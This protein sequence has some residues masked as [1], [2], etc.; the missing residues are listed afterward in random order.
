MVTAIRRF[1]RQRFTRWLERRLPAAPAV[2][3]SRRSLFIFPTPA[4]FAF[5]LLIILCWL[6]A[7]NY[8]NN[9]VFAVAC[10]L[11]ALFVVAILHCFANLSGMTVSCLK[12][13][14]GFA[15]QSLT[16]ELLLRQSKHRHREAVLCSFAGGEAVLVTLPGA[17]EQRLKLTVPAERRGLYH[18]GRLRIESIYPL[19]LLRA[20][21]YV[22]LGARGL[23]YPQPVFTERQPSGGRT[24]GDGVVPVGEGGDDFIGLN[25]FRAGDSLKHVA[26]KHYARE[27]GLHTKHYGDVLDRQWWLDW[28]QF[29]G[30]DRE[31]RL[32]R[33]CG[34]LL[35]VDPTGLPYGL[36]LPGVV[37]EPA[38][39]DAHR[40]QLLRELALFDQPQREKRP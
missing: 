7:T 29:P 18:L 8:E 16:V 2:T 14:P 39:G 13:S 15:G 20:W 9:L 12:V 19:G 3:L 26:W 31:A 10:L 4:G 21:T 5:F 37:I 27:Q 30:L 1:Y 25:R 17:A 22:D 11:A 32:S 28:E 35:Q 40:Q 33:L 24:D 23:V 36:R 6:A 38:T 34:L